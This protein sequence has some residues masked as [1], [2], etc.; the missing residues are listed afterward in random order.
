MDWYEPSMRSMCISA[1]DT[2]TSLELNIRQQI[3][4][5]LATLKHDT[6][7]TLATIQELI[8]SRTELR[9]ATPDESDSMSSRDEVVPRIF[10]VCSSAQLPPG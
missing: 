3:L 5:D 9:P 1:T 8:Q 6:E 7:D 10:M 4:S 2:I